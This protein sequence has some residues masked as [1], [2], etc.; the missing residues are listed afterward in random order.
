[1][2]DLQPARSGKRMTVYR[3]WDLKSPSIQSLVAASRNRIEQHERH[4]MAQQVGQSDAAEA[5]RTQETRPS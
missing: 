2:V 3:V 5:E 1:M 4:L